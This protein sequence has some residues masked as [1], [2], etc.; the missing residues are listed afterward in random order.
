MRSHLHFAALA[1]TTASLAVAET[2]PDTV[3]ITWARFL[4]TGEEMMGASL[5]G[6]VVSTTCDKK[7]TLGVTD[8]EIHAN[9]EARGTMIVTLSGESKTY[10]L[11]DGN[12][13]D[14]YWNDEFAEV[15]CTIGFQEDDDFP[16]PFNETMDT[17]FSSPDRVHL[18][19]PPD[20]DDHLEEEYATANEVVS[21][22]VSPS[23]RQDNFCWPYSMVRA[24]PNRNPQMYR[25]HVQ[26]TDSYSCGNGPC[27]IGS[28]KQYTITHTATFPGAFYWING[29]YNVAKAKASTL[30]FTCTGLPNQRICI[31]H[32]ARWQGYDTQ[33]G[34]FYPCESRNQWLETNQQRSPLNPDTHANFYCGRNANDCRNNGWVAMHHV[35]PGTHGGA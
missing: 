31:R 4:E 6:S 7:L 19:F 2:A 5:N 32:M 1:A 17:C 29:G 18:P 14:G 10:D 20:E 21:L 24:A 23:K 11:D 13:C 12:V 8:V 26:L 27:S 16:V 9:A 34:F 22:P 30:T 35:G 15:R 33:N 28:A 25:R 3:L